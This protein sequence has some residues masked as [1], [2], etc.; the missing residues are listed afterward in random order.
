MAVLSA[1]EIAELAAGDC[2]CVD[3]E[4]GGTCPGCGAT[5]PKPLP[6]DYGRP[7]SK[8]AFELGRGWDGKPIT[9]QGEKLYHSRWGRKRTR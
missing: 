2:E 3:G 5:L 7:C 9:P 6:W 8:P 4:W 1:D